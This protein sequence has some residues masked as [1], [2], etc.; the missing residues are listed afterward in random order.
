MR[1]R[2]V[3]RFVERG[4]VITVL[5]QPGDVLLLHPLLLHR[6]SPAR[7]PRHRRVIQGEWC[8]APLPLGATWLDDNP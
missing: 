4:P 3:A 1:S 2:A 8:D 6:S 5:A 7:M